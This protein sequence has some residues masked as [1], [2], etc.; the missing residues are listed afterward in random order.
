MI[1]PTNT[2]APW[3]PTL[4]AGKRS[5][6]R[7]LTALD[8]R[9]RG[10]WLSAM[11]ILVFLVAVDGTTRVHATA[12]ASIGSSPSSAQAFGTRNRD[13]IASEGTLAELAA[14][15]AAGRVLPRV[16]VYFTDKGIASS[17]ELADA[18]SVQE[19]RMDP[20]EADRRSRR[21]APLDFH[22]L[23]V[24]EDYL[25]TLTERGA[26]IHRVSRWLNA[27][28]IEV[29]PADARSIAEQPFVAR[30][31]PVRGAQSSYGWLTSAPS[32]AEAPPHVAVRGELDYGPSRAQLEQINVIQAHA[33]GLSGAGVI[34]AILDTGF[35]HDHP[36]FQQA[37]SEGRLLDQYDFVKDDGETQNEP[38]DADTQHNHGTY[39]WSALGGFFPG[40]LVGPAYGASFL[41]AKTE[42]IETETPI[43][44]DNW[45]AAAEWASSRGAELISTS[46]S[47]TAWYQYEDMNGDTA[48]ITIAADLCPSR[49]LITI[50]SAGNLGA[51]E[52]Y[53][54]GAPADGDS[55][56]AVGAVDLANDVASWSAH[57]PTSDGRIKPDV[58]ALGVDTYCA[59]PPS[60]DD[61]FWV[62]GTSLSCPLVTGA[63][64]LLLEARPT[65]SPMM[66]RGA[67]RST[68]DNSHTPDNNRGWGLLNL[69][70]AL[71]SPASTQEPTP[72][73]LGTP[74]VRVF[75][76]PSS[77][78]FDFEWS[79]PGAS[80]EPLSLQIFDVS[81]KEVFRSRSVDTA[82]SCRG[83]DKDGRPLP[84]GVYLARISSGEWS[85]TT[86]VV[87]TR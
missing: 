84:A 27:A 78:R 85:A 75:P 43:E 50:A 40:E 66:L 72:P 20:R 49:G 63:A 86:R 9:G 67:L 55:V 16:W 65:W 42:D 32:R 31:I 53:Y 79:R 1:R 61:F 38:G 44:E 74:A 11:A 68:A 80:T 45:I 87:R 64:A 22:D 10:I 60:F 73:I 51:A 7:I 71:N 82:I 23:P 77:D 21:N 39:T 81:G 34:V 69:V 46:L 26:R 12:A 57:G 33:Q 25:A 47:Y 29:S 18:L 70:A 4:P 54:I 19:T 52:W 37:I 83:T 59:I 41:L 5:A 35:Y 76:N 17:E 6:S 2:K 24:P 13:P 28:S 8:F 62:S 14:D 36:A 15:D 3:C 48:P 30:L 56:I 58:V